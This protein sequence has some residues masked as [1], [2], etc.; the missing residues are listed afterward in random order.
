M[1]E[2]VGRQCT[3][4]DSDW[5]LCQSAALQVQGS[6]RSEEIEV[7]EPSVTIGPDIAMR[8]AGVVV[9]CRDTD[10]ERRC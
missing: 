10:D 2:G 5:C 7:G 8:R 6:C 9:A 4:Q 1:V 3:L